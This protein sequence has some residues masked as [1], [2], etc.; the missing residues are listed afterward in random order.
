MIQKPYNYTDYIGEKEITREYVGNDPR[1]EE[2][3]L[4]SM[5]A[6]MDNL[7]AKRKRR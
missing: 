3:F 2:A 5:G 6:S 4:I 7:D 1:N